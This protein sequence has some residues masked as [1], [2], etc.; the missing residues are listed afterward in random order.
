MLGLRWS[1]HSVTL[2]GC[3]FSAAR[4]LV[5]ATAAIYILGKG[6]SVEQ[7][8]VLKSS[9][10]ALVIALD[11]PSSMIADRYGRRLP[12]M[13]SALFSLAWLVCTIVANGFWTLLMAE[14]FNAVSIAL[15]SGAIVSLLIWHHSQSRSS[16][17]PRKILGNFG[18][19]TTF[20]MSVSGF[21]GYFLFDSEPSS[22]WWFASAMMT[23]VMLSAVILLPDDSKRKTEPRERI[24]MQWRH[25]LHLIAGHHVLPLATIVIGQSILYQI[26]IQFWQIMISSPSGTLTP[27]LGIVFV[28]MLLVQ[29]AASFASGSKLG[30]FRYAL[31]FALVAL[32]AISALT[33][34]FSAHPWSLG[35]LIVLDLFVVRYASMIAGAN[36]HT[37][38]T[39]G[40]RATCDSAV[41][42]IG[43]LLS[44][45][46]LPIFAWLLTLL[47][48]FALPA[49]TLTL[50]L[51]T[52]AVIV[53]GRCLA[54][55][56]R[57]RTVPEVRA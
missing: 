45:I 19:W 1:Q 4:M 48:V 5:G 24:R 26:I 11:L 3:L 41:A 27:V 42:T 55:S 30:Q 53:G 56:P 8:A 6:I 13:L 40:R 57:D 14:A 46:A 2:Y 31:G 17:D 49:F 51:L 22:P 10:A 21:L 43:R 33:P 38:W 7:L 37:I 36:L 44:I 25:M 18:G 54:R 32:V 35:A 15:S 16:D 47:G 12:I 52:G 23:C 20:S 28:L 34:I 9:Q 39:D 29:S 50:L